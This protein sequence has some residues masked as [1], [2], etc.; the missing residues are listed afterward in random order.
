[1]CS[2]IYKL[3]KKY[4]LILLFSFIHEWECNYY[5]IFRDFNLVFENPHRWGINDHGLAFEELTN[6]VD[7]LQPQDLPLLGAL[8]SYS[9][10]GQGVVRS[11]L[12]RFL[13]SPGSRGWSTSCIHKT[14]LCHISDHIPIMLTTESFNTGP[15]PFR[16]INIWC[17]NQ[18]LKVLV[19]SI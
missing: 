6:I 2:F 4:R 5:I 13:I 12:D 8:Y 14:V 19:K 7:R 16:F 1:M 9:M 15:C 18:E 10:N 3:I 11:Q 17:Q